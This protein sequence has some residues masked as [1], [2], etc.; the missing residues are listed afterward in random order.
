MEFGLCFR[1]VNQEGFI[2]VTD[3]ITHLITSF[4]GGSVIVEII[5]HTF[6][7]LMC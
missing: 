3:L 7:K 1:R 5:F 2:L 6:K 4:Q